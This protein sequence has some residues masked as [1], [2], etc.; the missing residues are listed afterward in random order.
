MKG[1]AFMSYKDD[2]KF[3]V[4]DNG[5]LTMT[6]IDRIDHKGMGTHAHDIDMS[7]PFT[8]YDK[9]RGEARPLTD[10]EKKEYGD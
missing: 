1:V 4:D 7:V 10:D 5:N 8:Q 6:A 3:G 2:V 9:A